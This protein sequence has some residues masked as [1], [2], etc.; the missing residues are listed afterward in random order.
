L[1]EVQLKQRWLLFHSEQSGS[2]D[3]AGVPVQIVA[4]SNV[5][6][7]LEGGLQ[8]PDCNQSIKK[9]KKAPICQFLKGNGMNQC[10]AVLDFYEEPLVPV[11]KIRPGPRLQLLLLAT[12]LNLK[13]H[14]K[15]QA[16][17]QRGKER[18]V[19]KEETSVYLN[20]CEGCGIELGRIW[21]LVI[22]L[23]ANF[24]IIEADLDLVPE[25]SLVHLIL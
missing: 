10:W 18:Q 16:E 3:G 23:V 17:N 8:H 6:P 14:G 2:A 15:I 11:L 19:R 13:L 21:V 22:Q 24:G 9:K 1:H 5:K 20:R 7:Q 4:L 25:G 12:K